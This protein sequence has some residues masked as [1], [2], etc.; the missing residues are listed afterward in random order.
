MY[1][2]MNIKLSKTLQK[3]LDRRIVLNLAS[4][5]PKTQ[6]EFEDLGDELTKEFLPLLQQLCIAKLF[7]L[8]IKSDDNDI[9][10]TGPIG[11]ALYGHGIMLAVIEQ[12]VENEMPPVDME[13]M[14]TA[15]TGEVN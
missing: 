1:R 14:S 8:V 11:T 15:G 10:A 13:F 2:G 12:Q 7:T 9:W 4:P 6:E 3:K 5:D